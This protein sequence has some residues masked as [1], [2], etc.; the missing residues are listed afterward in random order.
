MDTL[1]T[2]NPKLTLDLGSDK[3][4]GDVRV[5]KRFNSIL[6]NIKEERINSEKECI[7]RFPPF[8]VFTSY[9][10]RE[11]FYKACR[12]GKIDVIKYLIDS[13]KYDWDQGMAYAAQGGHKELVEFFISEGADEWE[14]AMQLAAQGGQKE[15]VEY[16]ISKGANG[17]N[18]A[19]TC[20]AYGGHKDL[21][22]FL[23]AKRNEEWE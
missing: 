12:L 8:V 13:G 9:D 7:E 2:R 21:V 16:F 17:W 15:L 3:F 23:D 22:E 19:M 10:K 14:F 1:T 6:S 11:I 20:A 5:S 4:C 18:M